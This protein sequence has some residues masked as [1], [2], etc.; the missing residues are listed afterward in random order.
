M[1]KK[2]FPVVT[3]V[4]TVRPDMT[5]AEGLAVLD[6]RKIRFAPVV[7]EAGVMVGMFSLK[8]ILM[9]LL[10][11]SVTME[12]GIENIDFIIGA[13]PGVAKRLVKLKASLVRDMMDRKPYVVHEG[14]PTWEA[15]RL[16]VRFGSPLPVVEKET[17][18]FLGIISEQQAISE[19]SHAAP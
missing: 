7:D 3:G 1:S 9:N 17:G 13:A 12:D 11:V 18:K 10:P 8:Q 15:I 14:T 6:G 4:V 19:L 5:V 2:E 16:L